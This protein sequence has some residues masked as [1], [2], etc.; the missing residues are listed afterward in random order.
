M[1]KVSRHEFDIRIRLRSD[2]P[3]SVDIEWLEHAAESLMDY[4]LNS[5]HRDIVASTD[6]NTGIIELELSA[7]PGDSKYDA[8]RVASEMLATAGHHAGIPLYM[9]PPNFDTEPNL[10]EILPRGLTVDTTISA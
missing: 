3:E 4:F 10:G 6:G 7:F 9:N 1:Q 5:G 2:R 8:L